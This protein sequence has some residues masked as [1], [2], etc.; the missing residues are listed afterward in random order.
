MPPSPHEAML[1]NE[2]ESW[3]TP[4][5][6]YLQ[7]GDLPK[8]RREARKM[9]YKA[10]R[11]VLE[12]G[13]LYRRGFLQPLLKCVNEEEALRILKEVHNGVC[14]THCSSL[15]MSFK[16]KRQGFFWPTL[17]RDAIEV[18]KKCD[19]CQR[20]AN[21]PHTRLA[22]L[23]PMSSPWPFAVWGID[24]VGQLPKGKGV[25]SMLSLR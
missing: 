13:V 25:Y 3:M 8:E 20:L 9:A 10:A 2:K 19:T 12:D 22:E 18:A 4:I 6:R 7:S 5:I 16:I 23:I 17:K 1:V 21:I 11:Y 24:L 15:S 14:G